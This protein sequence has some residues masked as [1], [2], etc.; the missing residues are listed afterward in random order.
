MSILVPARLLIV[1]LLTVALISSAPLLVGCGEQQPREG[2]VEDFR[3][4]RERNGT[5]VVQGV[6]VN[7]GQ[8]YIR[9]ARILVSLYDDNAG[10]ASDSMSIEI[11]D[12]EPGQKK[13]FRQEV[14]TGVRL[15]GARVERIIPF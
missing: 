2:D 10:A 3:F 8:R 6:F 5:Q 13:S 4:Y 1:P 12:I 9:G 7:S 11:R 14:D 15:T